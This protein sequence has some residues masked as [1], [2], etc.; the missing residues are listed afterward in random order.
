[1]SNSRNLEIKNEE[2]ERLMTFSG[3]RRWRK[4]VSQRCCLLFKVVQ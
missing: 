3:D 4:T 2:T 1:M